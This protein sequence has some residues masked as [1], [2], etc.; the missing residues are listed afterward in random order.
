MNEND[1]DI[2]DPAHA[3]DLPGVAGMAQPDARLPGQQTSEEWKASDDGNVV[4]RGGQ[5]YVR[6]EALHEEREARK[7]LSATLARIEPLVPEIAEFLQQKQNRNNANIERVSRPSDDN[8]ASEDELRGLAIV[9]GYLKADGVT[10]DLDRANTELGLM[11]RI[12]DRSAARHVGPVQQDSVRNHADANYREALGRKF[13]DGEP[14]ADQK[15]LEQ[16]FN[17][18]PPDQRADPAV[19]Q[20][21]EVVAAGMQALEDRKAGRPRGGARREPTFREGSS[22]RIG[23]SGSGDALDALDAA[24]ARARGKTPEQWSKMTKSISGSGGMGTGTILEDI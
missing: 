19:A 10:P 18:V 11:A 1:N 20:M 15:Y 13:S 2:L 23:G 21:L 4:E 17:N 12:A 7:A 5:K 3:D 8:Y 6:A 9:R 22:G 16:V 14:I 24:A